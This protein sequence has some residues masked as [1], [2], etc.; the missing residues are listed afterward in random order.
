M[1]RAR[2][3]IADDHEIVVQAVKKLLMTAY[4]IVGTVTD[5]Q[6]LVKAAGDIVLH[7]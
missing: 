6:A 2:I 4:D 5:G 1:A 3:L 7:I